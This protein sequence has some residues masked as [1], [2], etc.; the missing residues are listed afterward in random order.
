M[1]SWKWETEENKLDSSFRWN[2]GEGKFK[3]SLIQETV[4]SLKENN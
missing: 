3:M 1:E 2:D 4:E